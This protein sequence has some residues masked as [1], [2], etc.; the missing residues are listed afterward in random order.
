MY[1]LQGYEDDF[2]LA[3]CGYIFICQITYDIVKASEVML[4][5]RI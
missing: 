5:I 4:N 2:C 3:L 1:N